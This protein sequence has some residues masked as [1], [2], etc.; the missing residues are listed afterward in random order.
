MNMA[1]RKQSTC[2]DRTC[3][4]CGGAY[5]FFQRK[6]RNPRD[7]DCCVDCRPLVREYEAVR[8]GMRPRAETVQPAPFHRRLYGLAAA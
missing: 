6:G 1:Q 2:Y 7:V 5:K 8:K 4:R 3:A